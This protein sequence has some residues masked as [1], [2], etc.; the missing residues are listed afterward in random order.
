MTITDTTGTLAL[1]DE[2]VLPGCTNPVVGREPCA[3]CQRAWGSRIRR[4]RPSGEL[5]PAA[6]I[7]RR[8]QQVKSGLA[9]INSATDAIGRRNQTCWLCTERRTCT[10]TAA[11]WECATCQNIT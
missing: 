7:E 6:E 5:L 1:L 3:D 11:G 4:R 10:A 2:C 8:D 9:E